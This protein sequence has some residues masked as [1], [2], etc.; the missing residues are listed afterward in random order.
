MTIALTIKTSDL[1][2]ISHQRHLPT[3][4][5]EGKPRGDLMKFAMSR[6]MRKP[7]LQLID[8]VGLPLMAITLIMFLTK[9]NSHPE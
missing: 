3:L 1:L 9:K 5:L 4:F 7:P 8:A 6:I 2:Q